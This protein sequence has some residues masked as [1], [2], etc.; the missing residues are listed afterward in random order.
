MT[1]SNLVTVIPFKN[2]ALRAVTTPFVAFEQPFPERAGRFERQLD[3]LH[4]NCAVVMLTDTWPN[5]YHDALSWKRVKGLIQ[6][7]G[8]PQE[9]YTDGVWPESALYQTTVAQMFELDE[10]IRYRP[11]MWLY[12]LYWDTCANPLRAADDMEISPEAGIVVP[13]RNIYPVTYPTPKL[14]E[15]EVPLTLIVFVDRDDKPVVGAEELPPDTQVIVL[16]C[17]AEVT[18]SCGEVIDCRDVPLGTAFNRALAASRGRRIAICRAGDRQLRRFDIQLKDDVDMSL[19]TIRCE[20]HTLDGWGMYSFTYTV[21]APTR[22]LGT[23]MFTRRA[24]ERYAAH[25][26]MDDGFD[27]DLY[28]RVL[29]DSD[30]SVAYHET[31][32]VQG[33]K[34]VRPYGRIYTQQVYNDAANRIRYGKVYHAWSYRAGPLEQRLR[35]SE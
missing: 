23:L 18:T 5:A 15:P 22:Q 11:L 33:Y 17:A 2:D 30:M 26:D 7:Y 32:L 34:S 10:S 1:V 27:Y 20:D 35:A 13:D 19:S 3:A 31:P 29:T 12:A 4:R 9:R 14:G 8:A 21:D 28:L 16:Q 25:P 24:L 6:G